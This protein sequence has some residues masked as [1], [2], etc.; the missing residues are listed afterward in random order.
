M[1]L[2]SSYYAFD[3]DEAVKTFILENKEKIGKIVCFGTSAMIGSTQKQVRKVAHEVDVTVAE[4]EFHCRG[5]FGPMPK[6]RPNESDLKNAV[7]F[8]KKV[9]A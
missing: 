9:I 4:A 8:A 6:G 7:E 2:G 5:T 3:V 1:F